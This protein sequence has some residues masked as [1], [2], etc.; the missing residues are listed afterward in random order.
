ML[1]YMWASFKVGTFSSTSVVIDLWWK[2]GRATAGA[3]LRHLRLKCS[4]ADIQYSKSVQLKPI[5]L[6][7]LIRKSLYS[8]SRLPLIITIW[9][10]TAW[11]R[12][13]ELWPLPALLPQTIKLPRRA[14][15]C[16]P[17]PTSMCELNT[18]SHNQQ[19]LHIIPLRCLRQHQRR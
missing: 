17:H 19:I 16:T 7:T 15:C 4:P 18:R 6:A 12:K 10:H 1:I 3:C 8:D 11:Q 9:N 13:R 5:L 14:C 2:H